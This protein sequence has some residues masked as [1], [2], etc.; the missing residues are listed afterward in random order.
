MAQ[1]KVAVPITPGRRTGSQR[2]AKQTK[3]VNN[4]ALYTTAESAVLERFITKREIAICGG[5]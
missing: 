4:I 3:F 1:R 5:A 2:T